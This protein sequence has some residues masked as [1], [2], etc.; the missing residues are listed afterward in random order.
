MVEPAGTGSRNTWTL[1]R[2]F[3]RVGGKS[4]AMHQLKIAVDLG[5]ERIICLT[6]GIEPE[7]IALQRQTEDAGLRFHAIRT[8]REM[9]ALVSAQDELLVLTEGVLADPGSVREALSA[10]SAV[11]VQPVEGSLEAGFE[12]IDLNHAAAGLIRIPGRLVERLHDLPPDC[13]VPSSLTR[14]ALQA[15]VPMRELPASARAALRWRMVRS[16]ADAQAVEGEWLRQR[17]GDTRG[18]SPGRAIARLGV[19]GFGTSLLHSG[20]GS[21]V[22]ILAALATLA[23]GLGAGWLGPVALGFVLCGFAWVQLRA[24]RLLARVEAT[25]DIS[26][27]GGY[28]RTQALGIVID[29][30]LVV[31]AMWGGRTPVSHDLLA[32]MFAPLMLMLMVR[33]AP[34]GA[35]DL[36][37]GWI[38]D[39]AVLALVLAFAAGFGFLEDMV[40][41][42]AIG[43]ALAGI[44]LSN[45][46]A[47]S[48]HR[49]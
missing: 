35:G 16:E 4:L 11:L 24:A 40:R 20:S 6:R 23:V 34:R 39:R 47:A 37:G 33:L 25:S 9:A 28:W 29:A 1:P 43:L 18:A 31:L 42:L 46:M 15:G 21:K 49:G 5:C 48:R 14:A 32:E 30:E 22:L 27:R 8:P 7:F 26:D 44:F 19:L 2:A 41:V 13:D 38:S 45:R 36:W 10:G 17:I 3:L 12:R